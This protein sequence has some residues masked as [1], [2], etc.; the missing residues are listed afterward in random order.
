LTALLKRS[1]DA[2]MDRLF[3]IDHS[4]RD[5][6][7]HHFDYV[8]SIAL[9]AQQAG[10]GVTIGCHQ[11]LADNSRKIDANLRDA[12]HQLG[13]VRAVFAET[14][15]QGDSW[16]AGLRRSKRNQPIFDDESNFVSHRRLIG[17]WKRSFEQRMAERRRLRIVKKFSDG[18]RDF[19][20]SRAPQPGDRVLVA[21]ASELE[22]AGAVDFLV[23][24]PRAL[25]ASWHFLFH[26]N[27]LDGWTS[28]YASQRVAM[29]R[30]RGELQQA[31]R[32]LPADSLHFHATTQTIAD[33][34]NCLRTALVTALPYPISSDLVPGQISD[35]NVAESDSCR[36][37]ENSPPVKFVCAGATR[38]E[39]G[40]ASQLQSLVD[41]IKEPLLLTGKAKLLVQRP[42]KKRLGKS[43]LD[44]SL[45]DDGENVVRD[46]PK[47]ADSTFGDI[48]PIEYPPHPLP[49]DEYRQLL[50]S[51]D[52]GLFCYDARSYFSR[53]AGILVEMLT[54]GKPVIVPAGTWLADQIQEPIQQHVK[55]F[56][57]QNVARAKL[58]HSFFTFDRENVP[59]PNGVWSF[60]EG[61]H[62]FTAAVDCEPSDQTAVVH[63]DWHWPKLHGL[64]A[65][66]ECAQFDGGDRPIATSAQAIGMTRDES[67]PRFLFSLKQDC[68]SVEF[69]LTNAFANGTL[70]IRNF[71]MEVYSNQST[72]AGVPVG[73]VGIIAASQKELPQCVAEAVANID[74]Y[75]KTAQQFSHEWIHRHH[76]QRTVEQLFGLSALSAR[77]A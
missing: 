36:K 63:F 59:G 27:L 58:G 24:H 29:M 7:G 25:N 61:A 54:C 42:R 30:T 4:L 37:M 39:K 77:V 17:R 62:P 70:T 34:F 68:R 9:A 13:D 47:Q 8:R 43:W 52:V 75:R 15:Y 56:Q 18:C 40:Q 35:R 11:D 23:D 31:I 10:I 46:A 69:R 72:V 51:A 22:V 38:R 14:V 60:D 50:R 41:Q 76:P 20:S 5:T 1:Y 6:G 48:I 55:R 21:A 57:K 74:H 65:R 33:Q 66:I 28:E 32:K 67:S 2:A 19:F 73:A 64:Y 71:S 49:R 26:F 53:C 3:L 45:R 16:L 44:L 12:L